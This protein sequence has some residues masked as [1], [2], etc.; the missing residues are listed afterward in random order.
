MCF[1]TH[2]LNY[3]FLV[4]QFVNDSETFQ[5]SEMTRHDWMNVA[6]RI[7]QFHSRSVIPTDQRIPFR[8][9]I[10]LF[11][12]QKMVWH[13]LFSRVCDSLIEVSKRLSSEDLS[14]LEPLIENVVNASTTHFP[15][16]ETVD[17]LVA[18]GNAWEQ[19]DGHSVVWMMHTL[20]LAASQMDLNVSVPVLITALASVSNA[21]RICD[22]LSLIRTEHESIAVL[23]KLTTLSAYY[24]I[25]PR[26]LSP[27]ASPSNSPSAR[28]RRPNLIT[29]RSS[30]NILGTNNQ[31]SVNIF[32]LNGEWT[33]SRATT[34]TETRVTCTTWLLG[35]A[36]TSTFVEQYYSQLPEPHASS[37]SDDM[38]V[39]S[40][41]PSVNVSAQSNSAILLRLLSTPTTVRPSHQ[42]HFD[43]LLKLK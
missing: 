31:S 6:S 14:V 26:S 23:H 27:P 34:E 11:E 43:R 20:H 15:G 37:N 33:I 38:L 10:K 39:T 13:S 5:F 30:S 8:F 32:S 12:A 3:K 28:T 18:L 41:L 22:R 40:F 4:A 25:S 2:G 35:V 17:A 16:S 1:D 36:P 7:L 19:R 9:Q 29:S 24:R 42:P 21:I